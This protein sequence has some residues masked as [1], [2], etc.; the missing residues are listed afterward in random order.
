MVTKP[1]RKTIK[2]A[3]AKSNQKP[4]RAAN[5][6][7][8]GKLLPKGSML[9]ALS[10]MRHDPEAVRHAFETGAYPYKNKITR[11]LYERHKSELQV[12]LLKVQSWVRETGQRVVLLFEGR[13]AAGKGGTIKRYM[14]HLNPRSARVI[15]L[16]KPNE[17][18]KTQWFFQRYIQHLPA[19]GEIVLFDRSWFFRN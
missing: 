4:K 2:A 7:T 13:D 15:A 3:P 9:H 6:K 11:A 17:R 1:A 14:E 10:E 8:S 12:E 19:A 5:G 18:E 16:E